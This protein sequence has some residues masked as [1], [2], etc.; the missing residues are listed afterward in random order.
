MEDEIK[1]TPKKERKKF[2]DLFADK[3]KRYPL[4]LLL[5]L[6]FIIA[7]AIFSVVIFREVKNL[8]AIAKGPTETRQEN[9]IVPTDG[10]SYILR[11]N[12]TDVQK[13][14]FAQLKDAIENQ[15]SRDFETIAKL[16]AQNYVADFYTWSNKQGQYD[17]GGMYYIY[18][19]EYEDGDD[20]RENIYQKARDGY[21][22]YLSYY[23]SK[24]GV[25]NLPKVENVEVTRCE[26]LKDQFFISEHVANKFD[27][28][29]EV[30]YDY[31]ENRFYDGYSI[32]CKWDY[33]EETTLPINQF[34][35]SINMIVID[36]NGVY[37][38]VE[39]SESVLDGRTKK[40]DSDVSGGDEAEA[41]Q[42][43][44]QSREGSAE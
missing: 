35:N 38:I 43:S 32:T 13:E 18:S 21:Y 4:M 12:A 5:M 39:T 2:S 20:F 29:K 36:N 25:E 22:K 7:I 6:P 15:E 44:E 28:E 1:L 17:I 16:I 19:G 27:E 3:K 24:Y 42:Q 41:E 33:N 8:L 23:S 40:E 11:D 26:K 9:L 10:Y 31:R 34:A 37:Y 14:Y 30:W